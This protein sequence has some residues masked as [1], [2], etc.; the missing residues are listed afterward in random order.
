LENIC[1]LAVEFEVAESIGRIAAREC[2]EG[3]S[4]QCSVSNATRIEMAYISEGFSM[5]WKRLLVCNVQVVAIVVCLVP[6]NTALTPEG[7]TALD[8]YLLDESFK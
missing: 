2:L 8:L 3:F 6:F 4:K 5:K 1:N 7:T